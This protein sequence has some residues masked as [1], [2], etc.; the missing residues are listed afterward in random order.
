MQKSALSIRTLL[1]LLHRYR[2]RP[3]AIEAYFIESINNARSER[4]SLSKVSWRFPL[5][6]NIKDDTQSYETALILRG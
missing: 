3:T 5:R 4:G 2:H 1:L 6:N